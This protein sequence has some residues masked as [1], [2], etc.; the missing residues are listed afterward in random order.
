MSKLILNQLKTIKPL[1]KA[2][3]LPFEQYG[4]IKDNVLFMNNGFVEIEL[5]IDIPF[6]ACV[7]LHDLYTILQSVKSESVVVNKD[8][9]VYVY[10]NDTQ[11]QVRSLPIDTIDNVIRYHCLTKQVSCDNPQIFL[12]M[13][14]I[15][16][17]YVAEIDN[18]EDI[19]HAIETLLIINNVA[20]CSDKKNII[21]AMLD[22]GM[23]DTAISLA[24][25]IHINKLAKGNS[26]VA[27]AMTNFLMLEFD[28]GLKIYVENLISKN[29]DKAHYYSKLINETIDKFW[30]NADIEIP[31]FVKSQIA[32]L[33]KLSMQNVVYFTN[34][35]CQ[36]DQQRIDYPEFSKHHISFKCLFKHFKIISDYANKIRTTPNKGLSFIDET[37][38]IR[39]FIG[40]IVNEDNDVPF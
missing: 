20:Y 33:N 14:D 13:C 10:A 6:N 9:K 36:S 23:P 7:N 27:M 40:A 29:T 39:G 26:I 34:S 11:Y 8:G 5:P 35:F 31:E 32:L 21:Q 4:V 17:T 37:N 38:L 15:A 2:K 22:F 25:I 12:K 3:G 30:K 19:K 1:I 16:E 18:E 24:S 28:N